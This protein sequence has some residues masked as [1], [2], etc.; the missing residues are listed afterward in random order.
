MKSIFIDTTATREYTLSSEPSVI[1]TLGSLDS[2]LVLYIMA[3]FNDSTS[4]A[5]VAEKFFAHLVEFVR[6]GLKGATEIEVPFEEID[7]PYIGK[8]SAVKDEFLRRLRP[9][10]LIELGR[11]IRDD[12]VLTD[13]ERKKFSGLSQSSGIPG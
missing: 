11:Q 12:N 5:N 10:V 2:R 1:W 7:L 8:R 4:D 9:E 13:E 6:F 3:K